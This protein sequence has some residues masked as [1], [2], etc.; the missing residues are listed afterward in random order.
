MSYLDCIA[1]NYN[2]N[3]KL[4]TDSKANFLRIELENHATFYIWCSVMYKLS[5]YVSLFGKQQRWCK[6]GKLLVKH[7]K[8]LL[9]T[10][11][12]F[13]LFILSS[14]LH[15][16]FRKYFC[17]FLKKFSVLVLVKNIAFNRYRQVPVPVNWIKWTP[18]ITI[19][20]IHYFSSIYFKFSF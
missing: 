13:H 5:V 3:V 15:L 2:S 20:N 11:I 16:R 7:L 18:Q 6:N 8:L 10:Y 17:T 19:L 14:T 1:T 9:R 4:R 12:A